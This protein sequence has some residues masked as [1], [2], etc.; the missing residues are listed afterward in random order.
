M[1]I[2]AITFLAFATSAHSRTVELF[3]RRITGGQEALPYQFPWLVSISLLIGEEDRT[4]HSCGGSLISER[5]VVTAGDDLLIHFSI[6][7]ST[8]HVY[9]CEN[10]SLS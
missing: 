6:L 9:V 1:K 2:F 10:S 5:T 3:D 8:R 4:E 7:N